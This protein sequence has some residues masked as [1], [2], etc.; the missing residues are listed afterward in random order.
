MTSWFPLTTII[1]IF[2]FS[3]TILLGNTISELGNQKPSLYNLISLNYCLSSYLPI[4]NK[5]LVIQTVVISP[6][7]FTLLHIP[8][9]NRFRALISL[10]YISIRNHS[11]YM[12][13][14]QIIVLMRMVN[15]YKGFIKD[16]PHSCTSNQLL[17]LQPH[18]GNNTSLKC[19]HRNAFG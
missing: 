14:C 18:K 4:C 9:L 3:I 19:Q 2:S 15:S 10:H 7:L 12:W 5:H 13:L 16:I 6:T 11:F 8:M 1:N 17:P